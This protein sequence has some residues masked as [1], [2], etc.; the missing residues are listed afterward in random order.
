VDLLKERQI[1]E[2]TAAHILNLSRKALFSVMAKYRV[3]VIDMT[4][5]ELDE[6]LDKP[7]PL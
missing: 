7:L 2:G 4:P 5:E 6:E 1:Y 3:P